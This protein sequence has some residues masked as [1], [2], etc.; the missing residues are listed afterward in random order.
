[1]S[2]YTD[3]NWYDNSGSQLTSIGSD[4]SG[5]SGELVG[6]SCDINAVVSVSLLARQDMK[7]TRAL[8]ACIH[9]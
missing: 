4:I 1:M 2:E 8:L 5:L 6:W 9:Q 3:G 7:I